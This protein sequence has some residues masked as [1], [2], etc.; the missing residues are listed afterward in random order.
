ML[1][2]DVERSIKTM[3][4]ASNQRSRVKYSTSTRAEQA[5]MHLDIYLYATTFAFP[6]TSLRL[7]K[8]PTLSLV[9]R[10]P[11]LR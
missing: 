4:F 7:P 3:L 5:G 8:V 2:R 9:M 11:E 6:F 1:E 10:G